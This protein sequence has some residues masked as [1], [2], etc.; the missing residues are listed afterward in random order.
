MTSIGYGYFFRVELLHKYFANN[1]CNDFVIIPSVLTQAT[2]NGNKMLARQYGNTLYGALQV[3]DAGKAFM[4][5]SNN[6]QLTFFLRLN[7]PV[8]F[9]YTNLPSV[10]QSGKIYYYTNRNNNVSNSKNFLSQPIAFSNTTT[11]HP[12][13]LAPD[14]NGVMFECISTCTGIFPSNANSTNWMPIDKNRYTSESDALQWMPSISTFTF[15]SVQTG[16]AIQVFAFNTANGSFTTSVLSK[17]ITFGQSTKS[18]KLD[19]SV[20]SPGKYRL[21]INNVAQFIYI[22]DELG[23]NPAFAVIEIFND[24]NLPAAYKLLTGT[25]LNSPLYSINFLNRATIWKYILNNGS[26]GNITVNPPDNPPNSPP[27][28]PDFNFP[29]PA[30]NVIVSGSP[31]PLSEAALNISL[32]LTTI[33]NKPVNVNINDVACASPGMLTSFIKGSDNYACS[34][35]FLNY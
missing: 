34:E 8:F 32:A 9:N 5:P 6:L 33:N 14:A 26:K 1:I 35:I 4:T 28:Q 25:T 18:F 30:A 27:D 31:I 23:T 12:G 3:D 13:D 16:A 21:V 17:T 2:L 15:S 7:N 22:N 19:L 11:Y 20:L 24:S 10:Y 29:G